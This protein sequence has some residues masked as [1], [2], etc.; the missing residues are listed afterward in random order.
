MEFDI[1]TFIKGKLGVTPLGAVGAY[2]GSLTGSNLGIIAGTMVGNQLNQPMGDVLLQLWNGFVG[3]RLQF[4]AEKVKLDYELQ[5]EAYKN[6]KIHNKP[7][8]ES[9]LQS[10]SFIHAE[11]LNKLKNEILEKVNQISYER[12][13]DPDLSLIGPLLKD[14][15][16]Y[17]DSEE[18]RELYSNLVAASAD[19]NYDRK[20]HLAF[21]TIIK[22]ISPHD[23][24]FLMSLDDQEYLASY[25]LMNA[26]EHNK[27]YIFENDVYLADKDY[28]YDFADTLS[29]QNLERLNL[30]KIDRDIR[31]PSEEWRYKKYRD[32]ILY[33]KAKE[34]AKHKF[35][36]DGY[37]DLVESMLFFTEWGRSFKSV[38]VKAEI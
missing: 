6:G 5:L 31:I 33:R 4:W 29:I 15:E 1:N 25:R 13:K 38:C 18:I 30:I 2:V 10:S 21:A 9:I 20:V 22:Q 14:A 3:Y 27:Y 7:T 12:R 34:A 19:K 17:A 16:Y 23:A 37:V 8:E 36:G 26:R 32:S 24:K 28:K 35:K 11:N